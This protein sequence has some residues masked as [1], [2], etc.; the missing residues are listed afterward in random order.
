GRKITF[1]ELDRAADA[2]ASGLRALGVGRGGRVAVCLD[3]SAEMVTAMLGALKSGAAFVPLDPSYP[4][5]RLRYVLEDSHSTVLISTPDH[6]E[7]LAPVKA[8]V[9]HIARAM[10]AAEGAPPDDPDLHPLDCAYIIYTSGSTGR[11]KGVMATH[12]ATLNRFAWMW[13][14]FPF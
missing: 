3:R 1:A 10:E 11:P 9:L 14:T 8:D 13:Q 12:E 4:T 5:E 7:R 6:A 2:V